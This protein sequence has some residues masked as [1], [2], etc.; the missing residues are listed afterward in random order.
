VV[1]GVVEVEELAAMLCRMTAVN[2]QELYRLRR[3]R[4]QNS[5]S[6]YKN[7]TR[8]NRRVELGPKVFPNVA[9]STGTQIVRV[10]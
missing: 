7:G 5:F 8:P 10:E 3:S 2:S 9:D 6:C 4:A 1:I